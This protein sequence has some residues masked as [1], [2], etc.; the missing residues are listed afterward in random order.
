MAKKKA[1]KVNPSQVS[2]ASPGHPEKPTGK[3]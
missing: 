2:K 3:K 1:I